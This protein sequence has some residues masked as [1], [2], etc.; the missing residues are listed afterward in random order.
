[1]P[2]FYVERAIHIHVQVHDNYVIRSNGTIA[3]SDTISTGQLFIAE[4]L[5]QQLMALEPYASHTQINRTTND[6]DD[7]YAGESENGWNP[8]ISLVAMDGVDMANGVI[9]YI[10]IG[11]DSATKKKM[12]RSAQ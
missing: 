8:D 9:G 4:D 10:T 7:I 3:S 11:V 1:M 12:K 5:S 2:G 6:I